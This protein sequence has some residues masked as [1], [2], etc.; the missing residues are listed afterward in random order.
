[1]LLL[2]FRYWTA[3]PTRRIY[4]V[5]AAVRTYVVEG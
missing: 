5:P 1:M 2:L 4:A 3:T